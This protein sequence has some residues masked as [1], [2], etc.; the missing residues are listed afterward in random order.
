MLPTTSTFNSLESVVEHSLTKFP[1]DQDCLDEL[2]R[3]VDIRCHNCQSE[4]LEIESGRRDALCLQCNR[5]TWLTAK[6]L[7]AWIKKP[8]AYLVTI[9]AL[10][11]GIIFS[12]ADLS[13]ATKIANSSAQEVIKKISSV[14]L[15]V[16]DQIGIDT[17][18]SE[19]A[20][21]VMRRSTQSPAQTHPHAEFDE[22]EKQNSK[23]TA[24]EQ[25]MLDTLGDDE[26]TV[27]SLFSDQP[28]SEYEL[29]LKSGLKTG[30]LMAA[31]SMLEIE[32]LIQKAGGTSYVRLKQVARQ[33]AKPPLTKSSK[34]VHRCIRKSLRLIKNCFKG[35]SRKYLQI[36]LATCWCLLDRS[37]W[38]AHNLLKACA[39]SKPFSR[40]DLI[41]YVSP[42]MVLVCPIT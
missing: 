10:G 23:G 13:R 6:S 33:T 40:Q 17:K 5:K 14:T 1:T 15:Q 24:N 3:L 29:E 41:D 20:E 2:M 25:A 12:G 16:M 21:C 28:I 22:V 42:Y 4:R 30:Q 32:L 9:I 26:K 27:Y 18:S 19:F 8:R 39:N 7:F 34:T 37:T 36:Y 35:V 31:L 38:T 11:N